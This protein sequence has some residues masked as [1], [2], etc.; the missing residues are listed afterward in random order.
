MFNVHDYLQNMTVEQLQE[1]QRKEALPY[2][3]AAINVAGDLNI[4]NML[5]S[6]VVFGAS[7]FILVG[8]KRFDRRGCVGAQNYIEI[9]HHEDTLQA[10]KEIMIHYQP[11]FIEQNGEDIACKDFYGWHK[12]PCLIFGSE[13]SG[14]PEQYLEIAKAE[15]IPVVSIA[16]IGI[17]RS[18]NVASAS[19]IAMWKVAMDLRTMPRSTL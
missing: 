12:N 3:V 4:S 2:A 6:A 14:L 1:V 7:K 9:E 13:S 19:A 17:I 10:L 5:R 8:K 11:V 15:N 18:L 16:Q